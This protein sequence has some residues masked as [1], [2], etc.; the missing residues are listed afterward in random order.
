MKASKLIIFVLVIIAVVGIIGYAVWK[1]D[2]REGAD[3]NQLATNETT[4]NLE[5]TEPEAQNEQ[6]GNL[7]ITD[8]SGNQIN[9]NSTDNNNTCLLYTS[10]CV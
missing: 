10:R 9:T 3:E 7:I 4:E 6:S 2:T 8:P 5:I 1:A